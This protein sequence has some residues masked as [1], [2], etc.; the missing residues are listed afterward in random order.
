[1][2]EILSNI[3]TMARRF[4]TA[5]VMNLVGMAM[6]Y[7]ICYLLLTQIDYQKQ[8]NHCIKEY[9]RT[10]VFETGFLQNGE[11][12]KSG[13]PGVNWPAGEI[14][15]EM[16]EVEDIGISSH[17]WEAGQWRFLL[18]DSIVKYQLNE[19]NNTLMSTVTDHVLDGDIRWSDDDQDGIIIPASI[20]KQYFGT[21]QAAGKTMIRQAPASPSGRDT[22]IVRG[23]YEDFPLN[24]MVKNC[25]VLNA[26]DKYHDTMNWV[27]WCA[28][29]RF[30]QG[31]T[32]TTQFIDSFRHAYK[33]YVVDALS[34]SGYDYDGDLSFLDNLEVRLT[35]IDQFYFYQSSDKSIGN[36]HMLPILWLLFLLVIIIASIN[37][38]NFTLAE[39][40]FRVRNHNIHRVMGASRFSLGLR[41]VVECVIFSLA[42]CLLAILVC[43]ALSQVT[44][45]NEQFNEYISIGRHWYLGLFLM[46]TAAIVG[47]IVGVYPARFTTSFPL[48]MAIKRRFELTPHGKWLR[49]A[50][51]CIQLSSAMILIV[52][53]GTLFLQYG[54]IL[55]SDYGYDVK[56]IIHV[57]M[58]PSIQ[59]EKVEAAIQQ[60]VMRIPGVEN[61]AFSFAK[62]SQSDT[63]MKN[64]F[65][66]KGKYTAIE[67]YPVYYGYMQT[68]G[69]DIIKGRDFMPS[70][71]LGQFY[72][73]NQAALEQWD[74][75]ELGKP[76]D[77]DGY[78]TVVGVCENIRHGTTRIDNDS[79][80][81][82]CLTRYG[83]NQ[84]FQVRTTPDA[85]QEAI[86]RK[87]SEIVECHTGLTPDKIISA[88]DMINE[89]YYYEFR[90]V[91]QMLLYSVSSIIIVLIGVFCLTLF[92]TEFRRKEIGIRKVAGASS[93]EI[94]KMFYNYY[95]I[96]IL[97]SFAISI[98][99]AY[100][101]SRNWLKSSFIEHAS[102]QWW[103]FL[104]SLLLVGGLTLGTILLQCWHT[105]HENPVNSIR[106][107]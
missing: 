21:V 75:I 15:S 39:S 17:V 32:D 56:Q 52:F 66:I 74:W 44:T 31:M 50:L 62:L 49:R 98:P 8:Y 102:I 94:I 5:S 36:N 25:I 43:K 92:E 104:L 54:Y 82:F 97:I 95:G 41:L 6:A 14:L 88:D 10:Y 58:N 9:E 7:T 24:S 68:M 79:P 70:D 2:T 107:E 55:T 101:L 13:L 77:D 105:A 90:F 65:K 72:I 61:M 1:M 45:I 81:V 78:F 3:V 76:L 103:P 80:V 19:G 106:D 59:T 71:P 23:V 99:L 85:D 26:K 83:R 4:K 16:P 46:I 87:V 22:L 84:Y 64:T 47:V 91:R 11:E 69:I 42:A 38:M 35:P 48:D 33:S 40:A 30:K 100:L 57:E 63:H 73:V 86:K 28:I 51:I 67:L 53:M 20:A 60:D 96:I 18:G 27:D 12:W 29:L 89:A 34:K 93:F 37:F